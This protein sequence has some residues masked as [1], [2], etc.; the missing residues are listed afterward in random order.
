MAEPHASVAAGAV[1][2]VGISAPWWLMGADPGALILGLIA[3][4]LASFW[5][6]EIS[7]RGRAAAAVCLS[8]LLAGF[9]S[10]AALAMATAYLPAVAPGAGSA[11]LLGLLI[12]AASPK[13]VPLAIDAAGRWLGRVAS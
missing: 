4:T 2:G 13:L 10:P 3:S 9:G 8:G 5:M 1:A 12:G 6:A 11:P 7:S